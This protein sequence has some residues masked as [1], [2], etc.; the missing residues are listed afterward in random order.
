MLKKQRVPTLGDL[1][2]QSL[3]ESFKSKYLDTFPLPWGSRIFA[4]PYHEFDDVEVV[5]EEGG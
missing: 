4:Q 1:G 2:F 5:R 3:E